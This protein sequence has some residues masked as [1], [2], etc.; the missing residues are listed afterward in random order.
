MQS[1][2]EKPISAYLFRFSP[3]ESTET[4]RQHLRRTKALGY[5][6]VIVTYEPKEKRK[7]VPFDA[8]YFGAVDRLVEACKAENMP[9]WI[10]DF[11]QFPTGSA[12]SVLARGEHPELNKLFI[13]ERHIDLCGPMTQAVLDINRMRNIAF[14]KAIHRFETMDMSKRTEIALIAC[15]LRENPENAAAPFLMEDTAI[16]L[17]DMVQDGY[18]H[19]DVPEG[20]WRIISVY[21]TVETS[22]RPYYVNLLSRESV[23]LEI[24]T[25]HQRIYEHLKDE[26]GTIWYGFFYDEP[27]AG[28]DGGEK[29]FDFFM[30][31]GKRSQ[32]MDDCEVYSWSPEMPG[33]LEKRDP[34]WKKKLPCLFYDGSSSY[35]DFRC[36]YMDAVSTLIQENYSRQVYEF[37]HER[38][39]YYFG[40]SLEDE[41]SHTRLG[42]GLGH[43]FRHQYYQDEAG[44]DVI[45]GQILP[46]RDRAV[47]WYGVANAD[48]EFY[49]YG[50]SKLASSEAHINP[51]KKGRSVVECFALYGQQG[52]A[53]RKFVLDHIMV[54]GVNRMYLMDEGCYGEPPQYS[55]SLI[56]Y[57]DELCGILYTSQSEI[58]TAIL[59]HAQAEWRE[60]GKAQKF[61]K[62]AAVLARNQVSYDIIPADVF[63]FPKRYATVTKAGLSINGHSYEALIIPACEKL[64][65]SVAAFVKACEATG[66]PVIFVDRIPEGF[67]NTAA[68]DTNRIFCSSLSGLAEHVRKVIRPDITLE[69]HEKPWLRYLHVSRE[70]QQFYLLHNEAPKGGADAAVTIEGEGE[71]YVWDVMSRKLFR[72]AQEKLNDGHIR[73]PLH[74]EQYEMKV[75]YLPGN[76]EVTEPVI[77]ITEAKV[78]D[79]CWELEYPDGVVAL[80][81]GNI[82]PYPETHVGY[83]FYGK[84]LYRTS[85]TPGGRFPTWLDLGSVSDCCEVFVNGNSIGKRAAAPYLFELKD[86][87][88]SGANMIEIHLFTSA[89]NIR[90]HGKIFGIPVDSLSGV[91][92]GLTLPMGLR[93]PAHWLYE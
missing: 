10:P 18:L 82:P 85:F 1:G 23:A 24:E 33:E 7:Q 5:K 43:Y 44:I 61:Q 52:L 60:G 4:I 2:Y 28:N 8:T 91:P 29:V 78:H 81:D 75:L 88:H 90:T 13:D 57:S 35:K 48:G 17:D 50:L 38:G 20:Y 22:G 79:R 70:T 25:V 63:T 14:G 34:D 11:T 59:Y 66:F 27:E 15:R 87:L 80:S 56:D 39:I 26:L 64:P 53:E 6:Q 89:S 21:T 73:L 36:A 72:P 19:W 92:Y 76:T 86:T 9:F 32:S 58:K 55:A 77:M 74:F 83:G 30:L 71:A 93:A 3:G 45:A 40:H 37:C 49:H 51:L 62:P 67:E 12:G 41:N 84:L 69:S 47:T 46:G 54:N 31:P 65:A 16:L 42:C 68:S